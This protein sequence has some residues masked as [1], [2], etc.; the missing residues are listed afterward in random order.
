MTKKQIEQL[1][2]KQQYYASTYEAAEGI[3]SDAKES[4]YLMKQQI[5]EKHNKFGTYFLVDITYSYNVPKDI[6]ESAA[7]ENEAERIVHDGVKVTQ[8]GDGTFQVDPNQIS[9]DD[10][11]DDDEETKEEESPINPDVPF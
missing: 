8:D 4:S 11:V 3:V 10:V 5:T 9:I 2:Q 6:M 1:N 7:I